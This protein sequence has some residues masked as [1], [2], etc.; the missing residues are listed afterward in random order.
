MLPWRTRRRAF[1]TTRLRRTRDALPGRRRVR[2]RVVGETVRTARRGGTGTAAGGRAGPGTPRRE[3][4]PGVVDGG[5]RAV[6][7]TG[8]RAHARRAEACHPSVPRR[9]RP[10]DAGVPAA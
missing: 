10:E 4:V 9:R 8:G 7:R 3:R 1:R 6:R 5:A 2:D